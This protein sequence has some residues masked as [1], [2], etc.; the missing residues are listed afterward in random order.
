MKF[1]RTSNEIQMG[2]N[3]FVFDFAPPYLC[4]RKYGA[5][6]FASASVF[7]LFELNKI[8]G[9]SQFRACPKEQALFSA[10]LY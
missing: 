9:S 5:V 10:Y 2:F 4:Y 3:R 1:Q 7:V 8:G 6:E